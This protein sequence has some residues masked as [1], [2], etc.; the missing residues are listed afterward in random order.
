MAKDTK[1][2]PISVHMMYKMTSK[3]LGSIPIRPV[4]PCY[5]FSTD[6]TVIYTFEGKGEKDT[7]F[8][9]CSTS[10]SASAGHALRVVQHQLVMQQNT[11]LTIVVK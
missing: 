5:V 1:T 8:R 2:A 7:V 10:S 11:K 3:A 9:L 4:K 6:N